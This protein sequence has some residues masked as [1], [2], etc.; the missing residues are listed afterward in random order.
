[1]YIRCKKVH[2]KDGTTDCTG[3]QNHLRCIILFCCRFR[4]SP[5]FFI[6][7]IKLITLQS[8]ADTIKL[9]TQLQKALNK[10][11][12]PKLNSNLSNPNDSNVTNVRSGS[13]YGP[14][15]HRPPLL[16]DKSCKFSLF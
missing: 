10:F 9:C 8:A 11:S 15:R 1:M 6:N 14:N 13:T 5:I 2:G 4:R 7:I 16:T 3:I 12:Q